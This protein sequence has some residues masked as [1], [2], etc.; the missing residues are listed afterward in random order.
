VK[1]RIARPAPIATSPRA[2]GEE[3]NK[4]LGAEPLKPNVPLRDQLRIGRPAPISRSKAES[5]VIDSHNYDPEAREL[6]V[7]TKNNPD[8][9]YV[10]GDVDPDQAGAFD[11]IPSMG[12]AWAEFKKGGSPLVA[13]IVNG[14]RMPVRPIIRPEDLNPEG[15]VGPRV[16]IARPDEDLTPLLK[17]SVERARAGAGAGA[18]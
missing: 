16:R 4:S 7:T 14:T 10:Y 1:P 8:T 2:I 15:G 3:L 11:R 5:S 17:K 9:T 13:K 6:H 18:H 12:K